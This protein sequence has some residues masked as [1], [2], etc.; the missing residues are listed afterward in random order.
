MSARWIGLVL[1]LALVA[2]A[3][4]YRLGTE[5]PAD[6][7]AFVA[8]PVPASS[9][10]YPV[11]APVVV[12]DRTAAALEPGVR[13]R[14]QTIGSP[15]FQVTLPIPRGWVRAHSNSNEWKW[16][17]SW[18][19]SSNVYF[20][21]VRQGG[22]TYHSVESAVGRRIADLESAADVTDLTVEREP[23]RFAASYVSD[24][25][26]R[27]SYEGYLSR[28]ESGDADLYI[29]VIGRAADRAGLESLFERLMAQARL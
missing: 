14:D 7:T 23:D 26:R 29:A 22:T 17:P 19:L 2:G 28:G 24:Q 8:G 20:I 9:P 27:F 6:P 12:A 16:Y 11:I 25:H 13:L 21:R 5:R 3:V 15:P 10:S 1:A 4:G 18:R